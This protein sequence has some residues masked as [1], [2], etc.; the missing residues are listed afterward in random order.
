M[1]RQSERIKIEIGLGIA[2]ALF[3]NAYELKSK[4]TAHNEQRLHG[5]LVLRD[6]SGIIVKKYRCKIL[7]K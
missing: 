7:H 4:C 6:K 5:A 1:A 3:S 2:R